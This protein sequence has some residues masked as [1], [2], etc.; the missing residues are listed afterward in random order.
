VLRSH[1]FV[2]RARPWPGQPGL[3]HLVTVDQGRPAPRAVLEEWCATL[4]GAGWRAVRTGAVG[5]SA[6]GA[7]LEGGFALRQELALLTHDLRAVPNAQPADSKGRARLR[8]PL[9]HE[10]DA[11]A[12]VDR[13]AFGP[14]WGMDVLGLVDACEATPVHRLRV[15]D[16]GLG[17][18]AGFSVSG[19]AGRSGFLQRL[20]VRPDAQGR[21]VGRVLV[22]DTLRWARR[23]RSTN[24]IVNTHVDNHA[25]LGLYH[26]L[27][28]VELAYRLSVLER[29]L[30]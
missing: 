12:A 29:G 10:L 30:L 5:P 1:G 7:Y 2:A 22:V 4:A 19:R 23:A 17:R 27:G 9:R 3:A 14:E 26:R 28:F 25:A 20:A 6:L 21:G 16:L 15:A 18:P 8:R 11:L 13:L 24:V